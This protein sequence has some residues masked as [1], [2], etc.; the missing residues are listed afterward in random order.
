MNARLNQDLLAGPMFAAFGA[1][2]LWLARD[3]PRGDAGDMGPGYVP[4]VLCGILI[5]LGIAIVLKG[6]VRGDALPGNWGLWRLLLVLVGML[7][8]AGL[9]ERA[10]LA[11]SV[12][13]TTLIVAAASRESRA[14]EVGLLALA[15]VA[16]TAAIFV[17]GLKLPLQVWPWS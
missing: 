9:V 3:Y 6:L 8:F 12:L 2:G 17:F 14:W 13:V 16:A 5:A 11:I 7:T 1:V 10:G 4:T 15:L